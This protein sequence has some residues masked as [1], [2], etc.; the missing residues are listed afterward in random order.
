MF[1]ARILF[2]EV[3]VQDFFTLFLWSDPCSSPL[4]ILYQEEYQ[5]TITHSLGVFALAAGGSLLLSEP[6][7]GEGLLTEVTGMQGIV[8]YLWCVVNIVAGV[9]AMCVGMQEER[10]SAVSQGGNH[11]E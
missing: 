11:E 2:K 3:Q 6:L 9:I 1:P 10:D 8:L 5:V 7:L 4:P